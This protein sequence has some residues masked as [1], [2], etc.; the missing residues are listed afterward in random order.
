MPDIVHR[1]E[2]PAAPD[3]IYPLVSS[4]RGFA[5]WWAED[6]TDLP[7]GAVSL[8]FFKR[9]TV[10]RLRPETMEKGRRAVW[11]CETGDEWNGTRIAFELEPRGSGSVLRFVHGDWKKATDYFTSCNTT[12]GALMY[13]LAAAA[14]GQKPGPLFSA[15]GLAY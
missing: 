13:R 3:T 1:I 10:Y 2:V 12:W 4:G 7:E 14:A 11:R 8:G 9:A 6:V 5:A 15:A